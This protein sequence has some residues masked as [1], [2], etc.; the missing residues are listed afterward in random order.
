MGD[1][2]AVEDELDVAREFPQGFEEQRLLLAPLVGIERDQ[3]E[4]VGAKGRAVEG[5]QRRVAV[6]PRG[7]A[8]TQGER[9]V[10]RVEDREVDAVG[11]EAQGDA[12]FEVGADDSH[13]EV[14]H[15]DEAVEA[16]QRRVV[17]SRVGEG[18]EGEPVA[19]G[20]R[21]VSP[22]Q[23]GE[24][25]EIAEGDDEIGAEEVAVHGP[26]APMVLGAEAARVAGEGP[27]GA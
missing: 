13:R 16:E 24:G 17:A 5:S 2:V 18:V 23:V 15:E 26:G 25:A 14:G 9:V 8:A 4:V 6:G 1:G 11:D 10:E 27:G 12:A 20:E 7:P 3:D 19:P 21:V 22:R